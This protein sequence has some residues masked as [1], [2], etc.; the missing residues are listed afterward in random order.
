MHARLRGLIPATY[1]PFAAD[2]AIDLDLIP[3]VVHRLL[4]DGVD[5]LYVCGSSGEGPSLA[6]AERKEVAEAYH[7]AA[8]G[9]VPV[10]VQV[11]HDSLAE[12]CQLAAHAA[13]MG[14]AATSAVCPSYFHV[15]DVRTV[16]ACC[17]EIAAAAPRIPF[18]YYHI[19]TLTGVAVDMVAVLE[20][21]ADTIPNFA[22]AKFTASAVHD[23]QAC[24]A[25]ADGRFDVLYGSD[26]MLLPALAVGAK[27]AVGSTYNIAAPLYRRIIEA[28]DA[29]RLPEARAEQLRAI[30]MIRILA[31]HPFHPAVKAVMAMLG[32]PCGGCRLPLESLDSAATASLRRELE[33][34]GFFDW[35]RPGVL[36]SRLHEPRK[37]DHGQ[38]DRD[39]DGRGPGG[40]RRGLERG[41]A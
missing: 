24:V 39:A 16:V 29:G 11:G 8:A 38:E 6:V 26:E 28:F 37:D 35:S 5:G 18:Y 17:A 3:A 4:A 12:A 22:G 1:T 30:R 15:G 21:A 9:R 2:G 33:A 14:A 34:I 32:T 25:L 23:Y 31:K 10:V 40:G 41:R 36:S 19:P 7:A 20:R 27:G 13:K